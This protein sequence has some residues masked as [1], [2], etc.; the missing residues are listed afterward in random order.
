MARHSQ[1]AP[2]VRDVAEEAVLVE[3]PEYSE[4]AA[5]R[6]A[7][8]AARRL[9]R[10]RLTGF[11]DAVPGARTLLVHFDPRRL[12][13]ERLGQELRS[14]ARSDD[15]PSESRRSLR[16]PV[17]YAVDPRTGP[18]LADLA[19]GAGLSPEEFARRHAE[20]L[21]R[22]AFV[23]FAPGFAYLT[24][25]ASELRAPRLSTPRTRVPA[26]SLGIGGSY[27]GI[28]PSESPGG[29][30][31]IG[32]SP[33]RCFDPEKDPPALM[34]PGDEVRF[35]PI[36]AA[37]LDRRQALLGQT[38]G[39]RSPAASGRP[40]FRVLAPGVLTS[41]QGR[42]RSGWRTYGVP[43]GGAMDAEAFAQGNTVL[44]NLPLA[45]GLEMTFVGPELEVLLDTSAVVSGI[46]IEAWRN[47]KVL[48]A[49]SV[50]ELEMGDRL[51][52]GRVGET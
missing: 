14:G 46:G 51:R 21:Y 20:G 33:I 34:L 26:G 9:S 41:V 39:G 15:G 38:G 3:Y 47:G 19:R 10:R 6:E 50:F 42:L 1:T 44:G 16:V 40:L 8:A 36:D 7:V 18:D 52:I 43:A 37:E 45:P 29:W 4:D 23:G 32:R 2:R 28:Y 49:G 31:L 24:G 48:E 25:L 12:S 17:H 30:R 5:N 22:V 13:R 11:L 35:E 27:T